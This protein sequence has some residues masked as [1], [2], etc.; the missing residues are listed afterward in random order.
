MNPIFPSLLAFSLLTTCGPVALAEEP[1]SK[2]APSY[3]Y[4]ILLDGQDR[5]YYQYVTQRVVMFIDPVW[6]ENPQVSSVR[7][8]HLKSKKTEAAPTLMPGRF[9]PGIAAGGV[10]FFHIPMGRLLSLTAN[11]RS[12]SF[13]RLDPRSPGCPAMNLWFNGRW[14]GYEVL[15]YLPYENYTALSVLGR[16]V[17]VE[18]NRIILV[19]AIPMFL[20]P[21]ATLYSRGTSTALEMESVRANELVNRYPDLRAEVESNWGLYALCFLF[22][23]L[24]LR[25]EIK[26][27]GTL[28]SE[29]GKPSTKPEHQQF[30]FVRRVE[31]GNAR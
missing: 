25:E 19:L 5:S 11:G 12:V 9:R 13:Q 3:C 7:L 10:S 17:H 15:Q 6:T 23:P 26:V 28:F 24:N 27:S 8:V 20:N 14:N 4:K 2:N 30:F 16:Y 21:K 31:G 22:K 29:N 1:V 18:P